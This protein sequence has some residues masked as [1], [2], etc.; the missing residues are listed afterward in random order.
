[1]VDQPTARR[2]RHARS[3]NSVTVADLQ[4]RSTPDEQASVSAIQARAAAEAQARTA[5]IPAVDTSVTRPMTA[6]TAP[7]DD[8]SGEPPRW[9]E[10]EG[11]PPSNRLAK[12]IITMVVVIIACG[13]AAGISAIGG[14]RP[15]RLSPSVPTV[16]PPSITGP[17]AVRLDLVLRQLATGIPSRTAAATAYSSQPAPAPLADHATASVVVREF[18]KAVAPRVA[19]AYA[20][21][22][23]SMQGD[24]QAAFEQA[25]RGTR[26]AVPVIHEP[27]EDDSAV[28]AEVSVERLGSGDFYR[29]MVRIEVQP[30]KVGDTAQLRIVGAQLLSAHRG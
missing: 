4:A 19:E 23:P 30:I 5:P 18:F 2:R 14:E 24:G 11:P 13:V 29:L 12:T 16:Q 22:G 20:L 21:L 10:A 1:M 7:D 28:I 6:L 17:E 25:W 8:D 26:D 9:D 15:H 3:V 27:T